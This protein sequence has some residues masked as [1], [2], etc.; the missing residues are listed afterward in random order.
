MYSK[1][2]CTTLQARTIKAVDGN[3]VGQGATVF[4]TF[5]GQDTTS[6]ASSD[7]I[8]FRLNSNNIGI[9]DIF[10]YF[11]VT[12]PSTVSCISLLHM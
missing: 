1:R 2:A 6:G 5:A 9:V 10:S 4:S 3:G 11:S 7:R 8:E 12:S